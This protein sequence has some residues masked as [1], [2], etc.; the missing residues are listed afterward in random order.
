MQGYIN[1][2]VQERNWVTVEGLNCE[3]VKMGESRDFPGMMI[4][5]EKPLLVTTDIRNQFNWHTGTSF[6]Y[7]SVICRI[8]KFLVYFNPKNTFCRNIF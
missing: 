6:Q 4:K 8:L 2:I 5:V 3:Y 1:M 7:G